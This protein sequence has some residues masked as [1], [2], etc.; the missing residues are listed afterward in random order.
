MQSLSPLGASHIQSLG[1][2]GDRRQESIE[3]GSTA[4]VL[5]FPAAQQQ[6]AGTRTWAFFSCLPEAWWS[7]CHFKFIKLSLFPVEALP[8]SGHLYQFVP[9]SLSIAQLRVPFTSAYLPYLAPFLTCCG[10]VCFSR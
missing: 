3:T 6:Q 5:P 2:P 1:Q 7:W 8:I 9:N 4:R 10:H